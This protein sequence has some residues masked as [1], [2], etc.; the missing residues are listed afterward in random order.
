MRVAAFVPNSDLEEIRSRTNIV[1]IVSRYL[2]LKK[3][4]KTYKG[5]C[6]FHQE[7]TPSFN[8]DSQ[9][10][11][12]YCFGCGQGGD[13]YTF[14]MKKEN[15]NFAEAAEFLAQKIGYSIHYQSSDKGQSIRQQLYKVNEAAC[16]FFA[17]KLSSSSGR[18]ARD[19]LKRRGLVGNVV[20]NFRLGYAPDS[21]N[22]LTLYLQEHGFSQKEIV[23]SG[24]SI[25]KTSG[26]I[27]SRFR[28]R[29]IF[30]I[31]DIQ[32]RIIGFGGRV[33]DDSQPKYLNSPETLIYHKSS[34]LYGLPQTRQ[35]I[36]K[37]SQAILVEGYTDV[38]ALYLAG[39]KNVVA[40]LGTAF[41][42]QHLSLISRYAEQLV[43]VFDGDSAGLKAAERVLDQL[44]HLSFGKSGR[45]SS[46]LDS[47]NRA[48]ILVVV[49]PADL[50]PADYVTNYGLEG[51]RGLVKKALP[52]ADFYL[53][54]ISENYDLKNRFQYQRAVSAMLGFIS[55]M[56]SAVDQEHYL[57]KA[58]TILGTSVNSLLAD[59]RARRGGFDFNKNAPIE[60]LTVPPKATIEREFLKLLVRGKVPSEYLAEISEEDWLE[61]KFRHLFLVLR[62][63]WLGKGKLQLNK[64]IDGLPEAE[65]NLCSKLLFEE[66][67]VEDENHYATVLFLRLKEQSLQ[68]QIEK[69][70][71]ALE[72][73]PSRVE[74]ASISKKIQNLEGE[75]RQIRSQIV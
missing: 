31:A 58:S 15:L 14:I 29:L 34:V 32:N 3:S 37:N 67:V 23:S 41:T 7:K 65:R 38:I 30:P 17:N 36:V 24:L 5:L 75:K 74:A 20:S 70:I 21:W 48:E 4:G 18:Q 68:R 11:L 73:S 1:D 53:K 45:A 66:I 6:P 57:K 50:D 8:V 47:S 33:L 49:L 72:N 27:Y 43:F 52:F 46:G 28:N 71:T 69:L 19:Y 40:T 54:R 22:E 64:I 56:P 55:L 63:E 39:I 60:K 26:G 2:V 44:A 9:K 35:E 61:P 12:F 59:L 13:V 10:Q 25:K 51:F 42:S 16:N 62:A